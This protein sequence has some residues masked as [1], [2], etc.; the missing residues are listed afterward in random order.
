MRGGH[1]VRCARGL[2]WH[3]LQ[4]LAQHLGG[5]NFLRLAVPT[6]SF[7]PLTLPST[8]PRVNKVTFHLF[9]HVPL[10]SSSLPLAGPILDP[11]IIHTSKSSPFPHKCSTSIK[12]MKGAQRT[13]EVHRKGRSE[14]RKIKKRRRNGLAKSHPSFFFKH[15]SPFSLPRDIFFCVHLS[16]QVCG[17]F[18][19]NPTAYV[20][21]NYHVCWLV[22]VVCAC[23]WQRVPAQQ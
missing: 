18:K 8:D 3:P 10:P 19:I 2:A 12:G 13:E 4:T 15:L 22:I 9:F 1:D 16:G 23:S 14:K 11:V 5:I 6:L 21:R 7:H 17:C 20:F